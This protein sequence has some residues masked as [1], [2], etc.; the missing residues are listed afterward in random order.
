MDTVLNIGMNDNVVEQLSQNNGRYEK[1]ALDLYRRF[2][3]NFGVIVMDVDNS[4]YEK[5]LGH[6]RERDGVQHD[7]ELSIETLSFV[8][9]EFKHVIAIPDDGLSQLRLAIA[10]MFR[11]WKSDDRCVSTTY[12]HIYMYSYQIT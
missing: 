6:A 11:S 10:A 7:H 5:I 3:Q 1:F 4:K 12:I 8:I 2:L 9:V